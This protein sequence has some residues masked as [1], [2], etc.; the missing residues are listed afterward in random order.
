MNARERFRETMRFG[1]PDRVPYFEEGIRD[2]VIARWQTQGLPRGLPLSE[3]FETDRRERLP[4]NLEPIPELKTWPTSRNDLKELRRRLDP[5]DPARYPDDWPGRLREWTEQG[6]VLDLLCHRG[7][8][9]AMGVRGWERFRQSL[10]M[11]MDDPD[12]VR[13]ILSIWSEFAVGLVEHV[14]DLVQ[15]DWACLSEP[16][17]SP[18]GPLLSPTMYDHIVLTGYAPILEALRRRGVETICFVTYANARSLLGKVVDAGF[19]CLWACEVYARS[20]DY[21]EIRREFGRDLRL[22]GGI[23]LD[24]LLQDK[25]AIEREITAKVP[26][27]LEQGGYIPLADGRVRENVPFQNY[28]FYR[29][30]LERVTQG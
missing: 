29:Q 5:T 27:L 7:F 23:D 17:G 3:L 10:Y 9:L 1:S 24:V 26:P 21:R 18:E 6:V 13:E 16:I 25:A 4:I 22:I 28:A 2:E 30:R 19:N 11:V 14:L 12:L 8:F 20:M 15:V